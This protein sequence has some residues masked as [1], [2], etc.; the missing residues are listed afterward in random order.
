MIMNKTEFWLMNNPMRRALMSF[1]ARKLKKMSGKDSLGSILELGC[2]E[3]QGTRNIL[4]LF[5]PSSIHAIDLD[6][7]MIA[8]AKQ[9]VADKRVNFAVGDAAS[10]SFSKNA[11]FDAV[12]DFAI[13][14]HIPNWQDCLSEVYRVLKPGG[15]FLLEDLSIESF[16][17]G[18]LGKTVHRML[19]HPYDRMYTKTAFEEELER[20]GLVALKTYELRKMHMFWK[21]LKKPETT[22]DSDSGGT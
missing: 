17:E 6:P 1:E 14:H 15:L 4:R 11:S 22:Q 19:D 2:G 18:R 5:S 16:T 3:G 13:I 20:L 21:V 7:K 8:R 12:F 9:R 10:L